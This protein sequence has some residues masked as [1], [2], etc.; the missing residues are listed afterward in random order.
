VERIGKRIDRTSPEELVQ[1]VE[2]LNE[3]NEKIVIYNIRFN[4]FNWNF[5]L[6]FNG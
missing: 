4:F 1:V 3:V 6:W 2:G 5:I